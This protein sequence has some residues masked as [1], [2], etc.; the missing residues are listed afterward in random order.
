MREA[1][2]TEKTTAD[3]FVS[4]PHRNMVRRDTGEPDG[5]RKLRLREIGVYAR[6]LCNVE[7]CCGQVAR[8]TAFDYRRSN[9]ADF[10]RRALRA[11]SGSR[12]SEYQEGNGHAGNLQEHCDCRSFLCSQKHCGELL[13]RS[14]TNCGTEAARSFKTLCWS[15]FCVKINRYSGGD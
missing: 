3:N 5:S 4:C 15:L 10:T 8:L 14:N 9:K 13:S 12:N 2:E 7:I 1:K 6:A 11:L